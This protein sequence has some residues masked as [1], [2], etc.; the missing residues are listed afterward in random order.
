MMVYVGQTRSTKLIPALVEL[1]F[2][3]VTQPAEMPPRR[4][5]WALDNGAFKAWRSGKPF[6]SERFSAALSAAVKPDFVCL[7]DI[8]AGGLAS[9]DLSLTWAP[10]A[11]SYGHKLALVVQDGMT[12]QNVD[13]ALSGGEPV[14]VIFVGGTL[15]WKLKTG[16]QWVRFAHERGMRCHVGRV[17]T[18]KRVRWAKRIGCDSID[19]CLPLFS[20]DNLRVFVEAL[21]PAA[22]LALWEGV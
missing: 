4:R 19:S 12:E 13:D 22:Q 7:P 11:A 8:V 9:L 1:G 14:G 15:A 17:G 18:A 21:K 10:K 3:E 2:G 16:A 5:P 20:R 6:D